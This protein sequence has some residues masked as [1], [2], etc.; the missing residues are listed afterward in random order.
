MLRPG[1]SGEGRLNGVRPV[2]YPL[3]SATGKYRCPQSKEAKILT[4]PELPEEQ[5]AGAPGRGW[6]GAGRIWEL[7]GSCVEGLAAVGGGGWC[8][9]LGLRKGRAGQGSAEHVGA[10]GPVCTAACKADPCGGPRVYLLGTR[11]CE[12]TQF[13]ANVFYV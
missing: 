11:G 6:R 12:G 5:P 2:L 10:V 4:Q 1:G 7:T 3:P 8:R 9:G 13:Y